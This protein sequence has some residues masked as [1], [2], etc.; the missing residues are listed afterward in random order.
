MHGACQ[1]LSC[2]VDRYRPARRHKVRSAREIDSLRSES[3]AVEESDSVHP[4]AG[5]AESRL[6]HLVKFIAQGHESGPKGG[7]PAVESAALASVTNSD[8]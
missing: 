8:A 2:C 1:P 5:E 7:P 3:H 4:G 6:D